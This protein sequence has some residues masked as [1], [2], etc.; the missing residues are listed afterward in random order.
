MG[1]FLTPMTTANGWSREA[2]AL[3]IAIQNLLWGIGQPFAG[4]VADR[5]GTW[6]VLTAGAALYAAGLALMALTTD[7]ATLSLTA[8]VV[9]GLGIAGSAFFLV[10]SAFARILPDHMRSMAFGIGTAAGSAGQLLFAPIGLGVIDAWG[11]QAALFAMAALMVFIPFLAMPL[12]GKPAPQPGVTG[13]DQSIREALVEAFAHRSYLYLVAGFFVCGF[14]IAFITVHLPPYV[15]DHGL[16]PAWGAFALALIGGFNILGSLAAGTLSSRFPKH[17]ILSAIYFSR[18]VAYGVFWLM[19]VTPTS[20]ALFAAAAGFL[21]LST[22]PPT[23]G[24]VVTM[25]GT[26]WLAM[27]SGIAFFSHQVGAFLGAWLGGRLYDTTGSYDG[28]WILGVLLGIFGGVINL[29][30]VER[31]VDRL[32]K[33]RTAA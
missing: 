28:V 3:A 31:P 8:G 32:M 18:A 9:L 2:F 15:V 14:H 20:V 16:D 13:R 27:L 1:F 7:E 25:F 33:L 6:R 21:W 24:L 5:F 23:H 29:P 12:A 26:R 22:V 17:Y 30:I 19:P 4:V 11:Y 10:L